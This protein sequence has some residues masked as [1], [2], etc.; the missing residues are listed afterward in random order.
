MSEDTS[1]DA[2]DSMRSR[3]RS[4]YEEMGLAELQ[5]GEEAVPTREQGMFDL[6]LERVPDSGRVLDMGCGT[7]VPYARFVSEQGYAVTGVD[8]VAEHVAA[9]RELVPDAEF[10]QSTFLDFE[11]EERFDGL[12]CLFA[13]FHVPRA[14]QPAVLEHFHDMLEEGAPLLVTMGTA[15]VEKMTDEFHGAEME[16]SFYGAE[17]NR[18]MLADAGFDV[19][20]MKRIKEQYRDGS[21]HLWVLAER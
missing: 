8:F 18:E 11:P 3:V 17:R 20:V 1:A 19:D 4:G 7:G 9:A 14:E 21:D 2:A 13:L 10:V 16:W 6:F 12:L 5:S 15:D